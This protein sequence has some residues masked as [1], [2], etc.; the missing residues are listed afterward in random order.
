[1]IEIRRYFPMAD[2]KQ[3][4]TQTQENGSIMISEDVISAIITQ[5][6]TEVEGLVGLSA[7]PGADIVD[8]IGVKNWGKGIK[9]TL[10][11]NDVNVDCNVLIAYGQSVVT[12][13][14]SVQDTIVNAVE[15][16]TGVKVSG[17]NVNVCGIVRQ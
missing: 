8:M 13:A 10:G 5:A 9:V 14:K 12:V 3:Y 1:M 2:N 16:M 7:K 6:V 17:V 15:S 4:I 11:E